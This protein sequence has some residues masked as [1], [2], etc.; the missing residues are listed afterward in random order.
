MHSIA[1]P[2]EDKRYISFLAVVAEFDETQNC[3]C[4]ES[5]YGTKVENDVTDRLFFLPLDFAPDALKKPVRRSKK[6]KA[7][8]PEDMDTLAFLLK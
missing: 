2:T 6:D 5:L 8:Q 1:Q 4:V 3:R 7:G